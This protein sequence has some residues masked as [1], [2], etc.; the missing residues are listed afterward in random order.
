[1]EL[2]GYRRFTHALLRGLE[3]D[4]RVHGLVALG[5]MAEQGGLPD[6]HSDHDFFVVTAPGTQEALRQDLRW[7]PDAGRVAHAFRETA[8]GL[9]ALYD[10]GHLVEFAVFDAEE[11]ALARVNRYRVLL[12]RGGAEVA[13]R[14]AEVAARTRE[15]RGG[16][17]DAWLWGQLLS[18]VQVG[19][20][21]CRR[22]EVLSGRARLADAVAH[23]CTLL[24]RHGHA[25]HPEVLDDLDPLR[26][27]ERAF[28][29]YGPVLARATEAGFEALARA[30][31]DVA[32]A[33]L[34]AQVPG[35]GL[36]AVR[37]DV[38]RG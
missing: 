32:E 15:T 26:R 4:A 22:G 13:R 38:E 31:L 14:L 28:P 21:R 1:M 23:L 6:V 30:V 7:L 35:R 27:V 10:D 8:H 11:L 24:A 29:G 2:E 19:V 20:A 17:D 18:Q 16:P 25:A 36:A 3:A 37:G 12:D 9:K 33:A 34:G 5:S